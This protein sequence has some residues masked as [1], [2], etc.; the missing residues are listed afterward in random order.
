MPVDGT[1]DSIIS[2]PHAR[3]DRTA[4]SRGP[5]A[6]NAVAASGPRRQRPALPPAMRSR[7]LASSTL[8]LFL[9]ATATSTAAAAEPEQRD[10]RPPVTTGPLVADAGV[11][12]DGSLGPGEWDNASRVG[13]FLVVSRMAADSTETLMDRAQRNS[14]VHVAAADDGLYLG[15]RAETNPLRPLKAEAGRDGEVWFDDS[16]EVILYHPD[17]DAGVVL[18]INPEGGFF[19]GS[20]EAVEGG[21]PAVDSALDLPEEAFAAAVGEEAWTAEIRLPWSAVGG[22][23]EQDERWRF[24]VKRYEPAGVFSAWSPARDIAGIESSGTLRFRD[25]HLVRTDFRVPEAVAGTVA[26]V[27]APVQVEV[28]MRYLG[29]DT[30][31]QSAYLD[32]LGTTD[33]PDLVLVMPELLTTMGFDNQVYRLAKV[34]EGS[35]G[36]SAESTADEPDIGIT[37]THHPVP[38]VPYVA[39]MLA[40]NDGTFDDP[41]HQQYVPFTWSEPVAFPLDVQRWFLTDGTVH[42]AVPAAGLP[43]NARD[44]DRVLAAMH[45]AGSETAATTASGPIGGGPLKL[46]VSELEPGPHRLEV[47]VLRG[48]EELLSRT[49]DLPIPETPAWAGNQLGIT[50][51]VLPPWDALAIDGGVVT[52]TN[53]RYDFGDGLLPRQVTVM[54]DRGDQPLLAAPVRLVAGGT[55]LSPEG[56]PEEVER[57]D[58]RWVRE[59]VYASG[60]GDDVLRLRLRQ[61]LEFDGFC[62]FEVESLGDASVPSLALEVPMRTAAATH[63]WRGYNGLKPMDAMTKAGWPIGGR[64]DGPLAMSFAPTVRL[65]ALDHGLEWFAEQ[66]WDWQNEATD[67]QIV[68]EEPTGSERI[69]RVNLVDH[70]AEVPAGSRFD[71][72][73]IAIPTKPFELPWDETM[74]VGSMS[75]RD[76]IHLDDVSP[77]RDPALWMPGRVPPEVI[78]SGVFLHYPTRNVIDPTGG[79]LTLDLTT[80]DADHH[81]LFWLDFGDTTKNEGLQARVFVSEG[82]SR[83]V[84]KDNAGREAITPPVD[85]LRRATLRWER[86]GDGTRFAV[87]LNDAEAAELLLPQRPTAEDFR[88]GVLLVGGDGR[89]VLDRVR[90][91]DASGEARLDDP[92]E[93]DFR[94]NDYLATAAGG[95]PDRVGRFDG[96]TLT[97]DAQAEMK[98]AEVNNRLGVNGAYTHW[99]SRDDFLGPWYEIDGPE[100]EAQYAAY[101][102]SRK[103]TGVRHLPYY[104]KNMSINDASWADFGAESSIQPTN[105]SFDHTVLAPDGPGQ[106]FALWGIEKLLT[107]MDAD[108]IH[109]DFGQPFPDASVGTGAGSFG[110]DGELRFSYPLL[111][112][113]EMYKRIYKLCLD[114]DAD[115]MPHT[116]PG[117]EMSYG[118]FA[119]AGVTGEQEEFYFDFDH[120]PLYER[121][122]RSYLADDRYLS[123]YPGILLGTPHYQ[124]G[125]RHLSVMTGDVLLNWGSYLTQPY[126]DHPTSADGRAGG[127][128]KRDGAFAP[129]EAAADERLTSGPMMNRIAP[130]HTPVL[131]DFGDAAFVP[132]FRVESLGVSTDRPA[133]AFVSVAMKRDA[134]EALLLV[135]NF[136]HDNFDTTVTLDPARLGV[137]GD[138]EVYDPVMRTVLDAN[139]DG[140]LTVFTPK[141]FVRPL[142]LRPVRTP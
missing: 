43:A 139:A 97:L 38:G 115:F 46:D 61:T 10:Y 67:R 72:G 22:R 105:I 6:S 68:I 96:G 95:V 32:M 17:A 56:Q 15:L 125:A 90:V 107:D 80:L 39:R 75:I 113:R 30:A 44:A 53:R 91:E 70:A 50:D 86:A 138:A 13:D 111:S 2:Y 74:L 127:H 73:L 78:S 76:P 14:R 132:F 58:A 108:F 137:D 85:T 7:T 31:S 69:L 84:L 20:F 126:G 18:L 65:H 122:V 131:A 123:H 37:A 77:A 29:R 103:P 34:E 25:D 130:Y 140:S 82:G 3:G 119:T 117:S 16:F 88:D 57:T 141:E 129:Y 135:G 81:D 79:S 49:V 83:L 64:L 47:T 28:A 110:P 89:L 124:L 54:L 8:S 94:P 11:T 63:F 27:A 23:P 51:E 104:L 142:I 60:T 99:H 59:Q 112:H 98:I 36:G 52:T 5:S 21:E 92:L 134:P 114:H 100:R 118:S 35:M 93:E 19:D 62:F 4:F 136:S 41:L 9:A 133:D 55:A 1:H 12:L 120:H 106:D 87:S 42:V 45:P 24:N 121:P 128:L 66:D 26:D 101:H 116:S 71:F 102:A 48:D 40:S 33:E 109:L